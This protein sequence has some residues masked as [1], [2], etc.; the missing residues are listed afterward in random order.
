M[1][2]IAAIVSVIA[3]L[4]AMVLFAVARCLLFWF[5]RSALNRRSCLIAVLAIP[6]L[7]P[8]LWIIATLIDW[9]LPIP[10][11]PLPD[12]GSGESM[13]AVAFG[14]VAAYLVANVIVRFADL[15]PVQR[16]KKLDCTD[17]SSVGAEQVTASNDSHAAF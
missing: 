9:G 2:P 15:R 17:D 1:G 3:A 14:V 6:L 11:P 16:H 10:R 4:T 5:N 7:I 13:M 8:A 12:P